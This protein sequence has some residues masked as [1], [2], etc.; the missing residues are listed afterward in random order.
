MKKLTFGVPEELTPSVFCKHFDYRETQIQYPVERITFFTNARGCCLR[1][2][3]GEAEQIYGLG[4]QLKCF[5]LRGRKL[6]LRPNA[7]PVAA[8][9]DSHAPVPFFVSTAGYGIYVDT[10]RYAEFYFG[11]SD[12]LKQQRSE[13]QKHTIGT[14][15]EELY[16]IRSGNKSNI[17]IQIPAAKGVDIYIIE[18]KDI[19]DIVAQYNM[20]AGGGC[21]A[22]DWALGALYRCYSK[23][24]QEQ[25]LALAR[26]FKDQDL[27]IS[28]IGLEPGW[29]THS[30]ADTYV[31]N[32]ELYP[33]PQGLITQLSE[34][35]LHVNLWEHAFVHPDSPVYEKILPYCGDYAVWGGCVPDFALPEARQ[36]FADYQKK[37]VAMG[38]DGFK[39][40][41]C[42]SS[43][44]TGSW[45]F[46]NMAQFPSG[47][48]GEQYHS[49][50]GVLYMQTMLEALGDNPVLSEVRNAGALSAPYP[51]VLYSDLYDHKDFIRGCC[52]AGFAGILWT[53]EVR[54]AGTKEELLRRL[55]STV[56]SVQCLINAWYCEEVPWKNY[57]CEEEVKELLRIR[58]SLIP[59]LAE[60]F[61]KYQ[62]TGI[63]PVRALVSDY[64]HDVQ[65]YDI[66]DEYIFCDTLIVAP[67]AVKN[68]SRRIYLPEGNWRDYFTKEPVESGW[69]EVTTQS[70]PV[71]EKVEAVVKE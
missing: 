40:D 65:T 7:D 57:D 50:F 69:F 61:R 52:T 64:S 22:P 56:F 35:D 47:L 21:T 31:W 8:T 4:L 48:D 12:L 38:V 36:I 23:Y 45:S 5:N 9:G 39:L 24:T 18:G 3:L 70:I 11:S 66:D 20:L 43:D 68:D 54:N 15:T 55:Q 59:M 53:P 14:S 17:T 46:P 30:Y 37:L 26:Q 13:S 58:E 41:E 27:K 2:P 6:T 32:K 10:A 62:A 60:S 33:D 34:M 63:P 42:D 51:F 71:Y 1:L 19:T 16:A 49:L 28:T 25:V 67:I 44:M 29:M